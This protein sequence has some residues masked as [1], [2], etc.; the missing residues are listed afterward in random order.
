MSAGAPGTAA[1][2]PSPERIFLIGYR[3]TGK[4]TVAQK[5][6]ERL[7][8]EWLDADVVFEKTHGRTIAAVF[9]GDGET[10]FRDLESKL[11]AE[12]CRESRVII[13]TGG[14]V[15]LREENRARLRAS[16]RVIWL[17]ADA[18]T[19][20]QRIQH[21]PATSAMRPNLTTGGL[22]EINDLLRVREPLYRSN[23]DF[24]VDTTA[25]TSEQVVAAIAKWLESRSAPS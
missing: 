19:I 10:V 16:G 23:A 21:D 8:W 2:E 13:A 14:G 11:L 24:T 5:L 7:G 3:G 20:W 25:L 12:L 22:H 18:G 17:T 1:V 6:S 9:A 15:V 4:S